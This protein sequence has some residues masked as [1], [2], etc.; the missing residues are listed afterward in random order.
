MADFGG[1]GC[2]IEKVE[3]MR[4]RGKIDALPHGNFI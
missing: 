4:I 3:N 2:S 1:N